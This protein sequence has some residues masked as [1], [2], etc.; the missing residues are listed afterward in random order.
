M[1]LR[2]ITIYGCVEVGHFIENARFI[3]STSTTTVD[4]NWNTGCVHTVLLMWP[5]FASTTPARR[6]P[7]NDI[8]VWYLVLSWIIFNWTAE[9][10]LLLSS[11]SRWY[12]QTVVHFPESRKNSLYARKTLLI[13]SILVLVKLQMLFIPNK[14][15]EDEIWYTSKLTNYHIGCW[16]TNNPAVD[17]LMKQRCGWKT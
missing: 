9:S 5:T 17:E 10:T 11:W 1:C 8:R 13:T 4:V 16:N 6:C 15:P 2:N 3:L 7:C 14:T 12:Q